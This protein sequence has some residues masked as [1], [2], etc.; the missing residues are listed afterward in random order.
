MPLKLALWN[1]NGISGKITE[2]REL[3]QMHNIHILLLAE[4]RLPNNYIFQLRG[5]SVVEKRGPV[6]H[7]GVAI[8]VR[9]DVTDS[10]T[11]QH[12]RGLRKQRYS[13]S[14][15]PSVILEQPC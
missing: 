2:A 4:T 11:I 10:C 9:N 5:Y 14:V 6:G 8:A 13:L 15:I 3:L 7:G 1:C 12:F